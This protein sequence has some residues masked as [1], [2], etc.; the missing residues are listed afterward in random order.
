M[1]DVLLACP[2]CHCREQFPLAYDE[3][4]DT[5][6]GLLICNILAYENPLIRSETACDGT[7]PCHTLVGV[8]PVFNLV[9]GA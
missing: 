5:I 6:T 3:T 9:I 4:R 1:K 7:C 8:M 2:N